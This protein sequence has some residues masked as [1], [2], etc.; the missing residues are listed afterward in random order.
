[1]RS[2]TRPTFWRC[3]R[4]LPED[5][6][7]E[8]RLAYRMWLTDPYQPS[9]RFKSMSGKSNLWSVRVNNRGYRVMGVRE[10]DLM[11]WFFVGRHDEYLR[12]VK[13]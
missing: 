8:V 6:R 7:R 12:S 11:T 9:L 13:N 1:M 3:Y 4:G 2:E 10:K 5:V